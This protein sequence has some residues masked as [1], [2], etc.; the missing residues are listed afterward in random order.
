M[1]SA[2]VLYDA[3]IVLA[4][5]QGAPLLAALAEP[6]RGSTPGTSTIWSP[7]LTV[8]PP[9]SKSSGSAPRAGPVVA[10]NALSGPVLGGVQGPEP[11]PNLVAYSGGN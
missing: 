11:A 2:S 3:V 7:G 10:G 4:S 6:T 5:K 8:S 1:A 9:S